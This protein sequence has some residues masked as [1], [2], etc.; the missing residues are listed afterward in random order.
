MQRST[1][2]I[3]E[4]QSLFVPYVPKTHSDTIKENV[5]PKRATCDMHVLMHACSSDGLAGMLRSL[6]YGTY[7][8]N[9]DPS[10]RS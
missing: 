3:A 5:P 8:R 7:V 4:Q 9:L 1:A 10:M 6:G 2:Y